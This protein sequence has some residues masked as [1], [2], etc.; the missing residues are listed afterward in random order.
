MFMK[1]SF[2]FAISFFSNLAFSA[3]VAPIPVK[4]HFFEALS[5]KDTTSST[6]FQKE[7]EDAVATGKKLMTEELSSCGYQVEE[8]QGKDPRIQH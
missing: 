2:F 8:P 7:F 4:I 5:P 6:R 3:V 1:L